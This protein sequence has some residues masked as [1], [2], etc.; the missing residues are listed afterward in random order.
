MTTTTT[1]IITTTFTTT[2]TTTTIPKYTVFIRCTILSRFVDGLPVDKMLCS[3]ASH[4]EE[5]GL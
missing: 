2:T 1:T 4:V 3:M 5:Y